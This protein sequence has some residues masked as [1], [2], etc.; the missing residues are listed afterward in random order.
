MQLLIY[1]CRTVFVLQQVS[2]NLA[3]FPNGLQK[4]QASPDKLSWRS[5]LC[6]MTFALTIPLIAMDKLIHKF[7]SCQ[8][9]VILQVS[10]Q[11]GN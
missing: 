10:V 5:L 2:T 9:I 1:K 11:D 6:A 8:Q 3:T 4:G 7:Q